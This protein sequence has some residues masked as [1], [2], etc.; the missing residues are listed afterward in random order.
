MNKQST[1]YITFVKE[2]TPIT[3]NNAEHIAKD[4]PLNARSFILISDTDA[5]IT[6]IT[7]GIKDR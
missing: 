4:T 2:L 6:P 1:I 3:P 5:K 7:I